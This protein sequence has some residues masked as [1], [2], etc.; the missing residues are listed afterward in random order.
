MATDAVDP[1]SAVESRF[2]SGGESRC[3]IGASRRP[4]QGDL[5]HLLAPFRIINIK[6]RKLVIRVEWYVQPDGVGR[7]DHDLNSHLCV[8][9]WEF[10]SDWVLVTVLALYRQF[11]KIERPGSLS[12]NRHVVRMFERVVC[13]I[14]DTYDYSSSSFVV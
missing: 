11:V 10:Q 2:G 3:T 14:S 13:E 8:I 6:D 1:P 12:S 7:A 5:L 4:L 9:V